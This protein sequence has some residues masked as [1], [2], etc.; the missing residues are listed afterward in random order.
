MGTTTE[1][2]TPTEQIAQSTLDTAAFET[3]QTFETN[4]ETFTPAE[5]ITQ[6]TFDTTAFE[7]AQT[8]ETTAETFTPAEQITQPTFDTTAFETAQ[9]F[10]TTTE[11]YAPTKQ[12][13]QP[14]K[15]E[16][17]IPTY[18]T[19][20]GLE[21]INTASTIDTNGFTTNNQILETTPSF[22][23]DEF[24]TTPVLDSNAYQT[25]EQ[26]TTTTNI[27]T[28]F[29]GTNTQTYDNYAFKTATT[30]LPKEEIKLSEKSPIIEPGI[31]LINLQTI[32]S[33]DVILTEN[34]TFETSP[35]YYTSATKQIT[36]VPQTTTT[37]ETKTIQKPLT[38]SSY[39]PSVNLPKY[40]V[41]PIKLPQPIV[42][43]TLDTGLTFGEPKTSKNINIISTY[44]PNI[45]MVP[46]VKIQKSKPIIVK[47]PKIKKVFVPKVKKVYIPS[48]KKIYI[49]R[50]EPSTVTNIPNYSTKTSISY[51]PPIASVVPIKKTSTVIP[52]T[53]ISMVPNTVKTSSNTKNQ[54]SMV[55]PVSL[56][57]K[58]IATVQ[59][60]FSTSS[61]YPYQSMTT[62]PYQSMATV[63]YQS[64]TTVPYQSRTTPINTISSTQVIPQ[65]IQQVQSMVPMPNI[66][67]AYT[68]V[69]G[70]TYYSHL[71][72]AKP[73]A[74][75]A[76]TYRPHNGSHLPF[77]YISNGSRN[78]LQSNMLNPGYYQSRTYHARR[79]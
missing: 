9:T 50:T 4:A 11:T 56:T 2:Y 46:N 10:K 20:S 59:K 16:E 5:Q 69:G 61:A 60:T 45:S 1:T 57:Y 76:S 54:I 49:Q 36:T 64:M 30:S 24:K 23:I 44:N 7:T 29:V 8:F 70:R 78:N 52:S 15:L 39:V 37:I 66:G 71:G 35:T 73:H 43:T 47:V 3:A 12:I 48:K 79:L 17:T 33:K 27:D 51:V 26:I 18:E 72:M 62:V 19:T 68:P 55:P 34:Q 41:A 38:I 32:P 65:N 67:Q 25:N 28:N 21:T 42:S 40:N 58:P 6:P 75:N 14:I 63:P 13:T 53:S 31:D 74:F 22:N 77:Y